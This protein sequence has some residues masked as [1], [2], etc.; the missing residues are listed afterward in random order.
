MFFDRNPKPP[1]LNYSIF[2]EGWISTNLP[3]PQE[4]A[5]IVTGFL[6]KKLKPAQNLVSEDINLDIHH[7]LMRG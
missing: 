4:A 5:I 3:K 6:S 7:N 2:L 1:S